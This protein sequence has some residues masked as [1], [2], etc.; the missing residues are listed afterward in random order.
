MIVQFNVF[1]EHLFCFIIAQFFSI[2]NCESTAAKSSVQ[3]LLKISGYF[4]THTRDYD[5]IQVSKIRERR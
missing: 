2:V 5:I 4:L 1:W 3:V